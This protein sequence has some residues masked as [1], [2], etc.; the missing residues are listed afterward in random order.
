MLLQ[1]WRA[2]LQVGQRGC[3][4]T[5]ALDCSSVLFWVL[6]HRT[7]PLDYDF[8]GTAVSLG[9]VSAPAARCLRHC[10]FQQK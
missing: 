8:L 7:M 2:S 4:E 1:R 3:A 9:Q 10:A 5:K 6:A